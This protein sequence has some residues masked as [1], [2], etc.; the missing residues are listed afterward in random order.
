MEE[1]K[2]LLRTPLAAVHEAM[3]ARMIDFAGWYMPVHYTGVIEEHHAVRRAAGLFDLSHMGELWVLGRGARDALQRL[4]SNDLDALSPGK[5]Q[6]TFLLNERGGI[7]DDLLVYAEAPDAYWLVV[8]AA[9]TAK[10]R[11][12]LTAHLPGDVRLE[13]R[14]AETALLALQGPRS[15]EIL[16]AHVEGDLG[17]LPSFSYA[18]MRVAGRPALVSR[19][20]YTGE[21]GFE[22]FIDAGDAE[23]LWSTL[24][25]SG[26][27]HGLLPAG[28]GARDTL[29][30][31][32]RLPLYGNELTEET[33]PLEAGLGAFVKFDKG[34]FIGKAALLRQKEEGVS[35]R[36]RGF[37][38]QERAVP[39]TGYPIYADA[40]GDT[41]AGHVTS[42]SF[43]PTLEENIGLG[44]V[45]AGFDAVGSDI[46]IGVRGRPKRA[47]IV[48]GR[49]LPASPP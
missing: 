27:P 41:L 17:A 2:R 45:A 38:M 49:F 47:T 43:S 30:L 19:T 7:V 18:P 26:A 9:N 23:G 3:G 28:L 44:Y 13:D 15:R 14:S 11:E 5:A 16:Q 1:E 35:R 20:G 6:Y 32:A 10:V 25:E 39:R 8:N 36:L 4:L 33:T 46:W 31:E 34:D 12:W 48:K 40:E 24:L 21:D 29:R 42:G 37:V 22:L